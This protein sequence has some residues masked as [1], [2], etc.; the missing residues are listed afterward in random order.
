M[1]MLENFEISPD[2]HNDD[3]EKFKGVGCILQATK[4]Q[5]ANDLFEEYL[6]ASKSIAA[7]CKF[8]QMKNEL[9]GAKY[10]CSHEEK[11]F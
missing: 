2:N 3:I 5:L 11:R 1:E 6:L 7:N 4:N 10:N 8:G 9:I